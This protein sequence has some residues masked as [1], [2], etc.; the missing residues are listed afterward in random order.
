MPCQTTPVRLMAD[1]NN[2]MKG[3]FS[4]D[5][6][7]LAAISSLKFKGDSIQGGS[8]RHLWAFISPRGKR[9]MFVMVEQDNDDNKTLHVRGDD[10]ELLLCLLG[11]RNARQAVVSSL[12]PGFIAASQEIF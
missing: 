3:N 7:R 4:H 5:A 6:I 8:I 11:A 2:G 9:V 1:P 12:Q 10:K